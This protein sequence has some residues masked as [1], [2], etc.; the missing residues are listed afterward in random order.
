MN[1]NKVYSELKETVQDKYSPDSIIQYKIYTDDEIKKVINKF[2]YCIDYRLGNEKYSKSFT[3]FAFE[4]DT[5]ISNCTFFFLD[6]NSFSPIRLWYMD[7]NQC[8]Y[9]VKKELGSIIN[10]EDTILCILAYSQ[11]NTENI[12]YKY[13]LI[14]M[15]MSLFDVISR[16]DNVVCMMEA[17]GIYCFMDPDL[18]T[19]KIGENVEI[20]NLGKVCN[21]SQPVVKLAQK[22]NMKENKNYY[23]Y[24]TLGSVFTNKVLDDF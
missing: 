6:R 16:A 17:T 1:I 10:S 11:I 19:L 5:L 22:L 7:E 23:H 20:K 24:I 18:D 9:L 14:K 21:E 15:Y 12:L 4:G 3:L 13:K 8:K 2:S